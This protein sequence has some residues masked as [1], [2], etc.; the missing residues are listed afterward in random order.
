M[1]PAI[2]REISIDAIHADA[3]EMAGS[4]PITTGKLPPQTKLPSLTGSRFWAALLVFLFHSS[5]PSDLAPFSDPTIQHIFTVIVGKAGWLGVSYFFILSGF[6][7]VW[8]ARDND[9]VGDFYLRRFAKIYPTHCL[10]WAIAFIIGAMSIYQYKLWSSNLLLLNTW[11][12]DV[13]YFFVG[14]R[15]SW[16]LCIEAMFYL[17][18]P[19]LFRV[20]KTIPE[21]FDLAGLIIV[22]AASLLVQTYIYIWV[23]PD[24]M[25]G[26][27]PIS[28]QHFW[29][30]YIFPPSR[31]FEFLAGMFAARLLMNGR[32]LVLTKTASFTLLAA[33]YIGSMYIPYQF[34]MSVVFIIPVCL[35]IVS[36][37]GDDLKYRNTLLNSKTSVWLG[38]IS[39]S[40]YM[41]HF[42]VL[43][44]FLNLTA[45]RKFS[46]PEG[47][48][49]I[50]V[51]LVLSVS[52]ASFLYKYFEVP[53]MKL[54]LEKCRAKALVALRKPS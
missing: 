19:F 10:T 52:F 5:L 23:E 32:M 46:L 7:M 8:S 51:A 6:I 39:Y 11:V 35:L 41:V 15:P 49:L 21:K 2:N 20:M 29:V 16:S 9:T 54:I 53:V 31:I 13:H 27:F 26:A 50:A 40:F 3:I 47:I 22:T 28:Q 14:N 17:S 44:Y 33:T 43:F 36:I 12:D 34:S 30:S 24:K 25:M 37:A 45:G 42:L 4:Q 38:E 18:F 48:A 1:N